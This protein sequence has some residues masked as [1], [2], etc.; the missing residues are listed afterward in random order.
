M[1][2]RIILALALLFLLAAC[3]FKAKESVANECGHTAGYKEI[4]IS[5]NSHIITIYTGLY[6]NDSREE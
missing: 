1:E 4:A 2:L 5:E 3:S 6:W